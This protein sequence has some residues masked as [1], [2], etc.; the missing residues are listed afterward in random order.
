M[1]ETTSYQ[2]TSGWAGPGRQTPQR[3]RNPTRSEKNLIPTFFAAHFSPS[4]R[5]FGLTQVHYPSKASQFYRSCRNHCRLDLFS[6][7]Q[8]FTDREKRHHPFFANSTTSSH[9]KKSLKTNKRTSK[10]NDQQTR[11]SCLVSE[12][13]SIA[14]P[15]K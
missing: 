6:F 14:C 10:A 15:S 13:K 5:R 7:L 12:N 11:S 4:H 8:Y 1:Y 3:K 2:R 9:N